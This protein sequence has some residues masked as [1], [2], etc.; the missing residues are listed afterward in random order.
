MI[1][2]HGL[3][4]GRKKSSIDCDAEKVED[5]LLFCLF[6]VAAVILLLLDNK[7]RT[8]CMNLSNSCPWCL[9]VYS[10]TCI[11]AITIGTIRPIP[12]SHTKSVITHTCNVNTIS[13][14]PSLNTLLITKQSNIYA[15]FLSTPYENMPSIQLIVIW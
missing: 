8:D 11:D 1:N 6:I 10:M 9:Y 3:N 12:A 4:W 5:L 13:T 7:F 15:T 2:H 14:K